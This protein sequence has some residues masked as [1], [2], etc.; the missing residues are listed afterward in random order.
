MKLVNIESPI[1]KVNIHLHY[2]FAKPQFD[3]DTVSISIE[4]AEPVKIN[5]ILCSF[6][7]HLRY[8]ISRNE[9]RNEYLSAKREDLI[10]RDATDGQKTKIYALSDWIR[11][12]PQLQTYNTLGCTNL[13]DLKYEGYLTRLARLDAEYNELLKRAEEKKSEYDALMDEV[14]KFKKENFV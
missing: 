6:T 4:S 2:H 1:G 14:N 3:V 8:Y 11:E 13:S 10:Y 12:L 9:W 7:Y 5:G